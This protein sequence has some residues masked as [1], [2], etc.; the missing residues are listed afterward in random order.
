MSSEPIKTKTCDGSADVPP[1]NTDSEVIS[2]EMKTDDSAER[3]D[4]GDKENPGIPDVIQSNASEKS[5]C[6]QT[7]LSKPPPQRQPA[8][9][10]YH[11]PLWAM[12]CSPSMGYRL[13]VIK[14]GIPL[15]ECTVNLGGDSTEESEQLEGHSFCLFGRQPQPYYAH[16]NN[17]IGQCAVLA[18][19]SISR[20]HAVLQYGRPPPSISKTSHIHPES[21][22]WYIQDLESTHGTFVNKRRLPPG[23]FVRVHVGY[24]I[25]FGGSTRLHLLQGPEEDVETETNQSWSEIKQAYKQREEK[26]H[27]VVTRSSSQ[28]SSNVNLGCDWGI[29]VEDAGDEVPNFLLGEDGAACLTHEHLYQDD[30]KRALKSYFEREGIDPVPEYEFL[31]ATFG[32]QHCRL[33]LPL[34]SGTVTAEVVV[35]GKKKE[36]VAACALEACRLLDRLGEFDPNKDKLSNAK[37]SRSKEYWEENDYYSSDED[38]FIDRTGQVERKRLERIR[39]LGVQ[40][41]EV[42]EAERLAMVASAH[43]GG[44]KPRAAKSLDNA[45][46]LGI[47]SELE[48]VG[49]EIVCLEEQLDEIDKRFAPHNENPSEMDELEAYMNAL[50]SGAPSRKDRFKLKTRLFTLRQTEMRLFQKAGLPQPRRHV[51]SSGASALPDDESVI[52]SRNDAAAAVRAAKNRLEQKLRNNQAVPADSLPEHHTNNRLKRNEIKRSVCGR[53]QFEQVRSSEIKVD[54]DQPFE[55]EEDE[56]EQE[57]ET[58]NNE[59]KTAQSEVRN[60]SLTDHELMDTDSD[61]HKIPEPRPDEPSASVA[62]LD[63]HCSPTSKAI[64]RK[65]EDDHPDKVPPEN[66]EEL[67]TGTSSPQRPTSPPKE[68]VRS[69]VVVRSDVNDHPPSKRRPKFPLKPKP[70]DLY[71]QSD[72]D[73]ITWVPPTDQKGD[74][75]TSLNAKY[76]Y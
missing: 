65:V 76:G 20:L 3:G 51:I 24:V 17:L 2:E 28:S 69:G 22:G 16:Y 73:Y 33:E 38:T 64:K 8:S 31:E 21:A 14:N 10:R 75:L 57:D 4:K 68:P 63:P 41:A 5:D 32:K 54:A 40:G 62:V 12:T 39:Q 18:H 1:K 27:D 60:P 71:Q 52:S 44:E 45:T 19:P 67:A 48:K 72:P 9:N 74:G 58:K 36:A 25:R 35:A 46:L 50:K 30:P 6:Q 42:E 11:P 23:R 34:S 43:G 26:V 49:Q 61:P 15:P 7:S 29:P 66:T 37:Q 13:E 55:V 59:G 70:T 53:S 56:D 47:L